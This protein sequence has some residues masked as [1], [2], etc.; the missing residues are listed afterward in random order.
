MQHVGD[1]VDHARPEFHDRAEAG[2]VLAEFMEDSGAKVDVVVAVPSGGVAVGAPVA[3]H[4]AVPM[5]VV[6]VRKLPLPMSPE[7][8]FGAVT[9]DR[10]VVLN[11]PLVRRAGLTDER[12][13]AIIDRVL[14]GLRERARAFEEARSREP[15]E[16]RNVVLVDDGLAS[17]VTME[18]AVGELRSKQPASLSVAVPVAPMRTVRRIEPEVDELYC[19]RAQ[20]PGSFAVASFYRRWHDLTDEEALQIL[21]SAG[22]GSEQPS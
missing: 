22:A 15:V 5:N 18:A 3:E 14:E 16:S 9:L 4:F 13:E 7:A 11:E 8:G 12:I 17:G 2:R 1:L 21:R 19:L 6:L 20:R 10:E